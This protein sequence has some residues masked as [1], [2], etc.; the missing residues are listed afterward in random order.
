M[1]SPLTTAVLKAGIIPEQTLAE[2]R[3]WRAPIDEPESTSGRPP[4]SIEEAALAIEEALQSEGYSI[5]RETDLGA[6]HQYVRTQRSGV[7]HLSVGSEVADIPVT[8]GVNHHGEY[9]LP[10]SADSIEESVIDTETY[11]EWLEGTSI[12]HVSFSRVRELY[13]GE[14]KT[15]MICIPVPD[16]AAPMLPS[17]D[18]HGSGEP[19]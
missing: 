1:T 16:P 18:N 4:Q 7:L 15:F 8:F 6:I 19:S 9:I 3:R 14:Q 13:Y 10:W 12:R 5:T 17:G 2:F 11:L